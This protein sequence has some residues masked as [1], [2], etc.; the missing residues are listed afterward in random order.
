[1]LH[2]GACALCRA[3]V[4]HYRA[5]DAN[6]EIVFVDASDQDALTAASPVIS[7]G[8]DDALARLHVL[9]PEG[10]V[11]TGARAFVAVWRVLPGWRHLAPLASLPG[12]IHLLEELYR[13][14]LHV[15]PPLARWVARRAAKRLS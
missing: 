12:V 5:L 1:M 15:R 11:V 13:L 8:Q 6:Q 3:E 4:A 14:S 10:E 9:T 7:V 2:D